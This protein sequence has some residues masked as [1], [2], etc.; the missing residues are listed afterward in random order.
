MVRGACVN[1][2]NLTLRRGPGP[3]TNDPYW[4]FLSQSNFNLAQ[5]LH[6]LFWAKT[7]PWYLTPS[8]AKL[9]FSKSLAQKRP[10]MS[11]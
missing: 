1:A 6:N 8:P 11:R 2:N 9:S 3:R 10:V 7:L 4:F 5:L